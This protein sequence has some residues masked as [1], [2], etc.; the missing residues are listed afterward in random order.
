MVL[1][2]ETVYTEDD[3]AE[4][5]ECNQKKRKAVENPEELG[6]RV[7]STALVQMVSKLFLIF[8]IF[9]QFTHTPW[10]N[11]FRES[12]ICGNFFLFF[13]SLFS[14]SVQKGQASNG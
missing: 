9:D 12:Y 5:E 2:R 1:Q 3:K 6:H 4:L 10:K 11:I 8:Y 13:P 7:D 14:L